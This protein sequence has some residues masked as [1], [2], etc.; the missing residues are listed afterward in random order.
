M[1]DSCTLTAPL[2][3]GWQLC[4]QLSNFKVGAK[5]PAT[6][7]KASLPGLPDKPHPKHFAFPK[8]TLGSPIL[9][10]EVLRGTN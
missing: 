1:T 9:T 10:I 8:G 5:M 7:M 6:C 2:A 3:G 4:V